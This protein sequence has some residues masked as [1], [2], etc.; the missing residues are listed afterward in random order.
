MPPAINNGRS[1]AHAQ[2]RTFSGTEPLAVQ[3]SEF[4]AAQRFM[5]HGRSDFF[6]GIRAALID[7]DKQPKWEPATLAAVRAADV[8]EYFAPIGGRELQFLLG[9]AQACL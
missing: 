4:R 2:V 5:A 9:T 1:R 6:E 3:L 7:K 8:E